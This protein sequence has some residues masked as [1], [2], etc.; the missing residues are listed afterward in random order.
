MV[1]GWGGG[2]GVPGLGGGQPGVAAARPA[3][4]TA[5]CSVGGGR[6][7]APPKYSSGRA[8]APRRCGYPKHVFPR[9]AQLNIGCPPPRRRR[10]RPSPGGEQGRSVAPVPGCIAGGTHPNSRQGRGL[11]A[12]RDGE[13]ATGRREEGGPV[14]SVP[15]EGL[16][17][18]HSGRA[19][20]GDGADAPAA[21]EK[22]PLGPGCWGPGAACRYKDQG[23]I[24][25]L[26]LAALLLL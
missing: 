1:W 16:C 14:A 6:Q 4:R 8:S 3:L 25:A 15:G 23:T 2:A 24:L 13:L 26:V 12:A 19:G 5:C 20:R 18:R 21:L 9:G 10:S 7:T 22:Q 17:G 11:G